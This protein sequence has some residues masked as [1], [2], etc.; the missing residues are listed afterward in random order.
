MGTSVFCTQNLHGYSLQFSPFQADRL[1]CATS[2]HYGLS[3]RGALF[4]LSI[5]PNEQPKL[6]SQLNWDD[7]LFDVAWSEENPEIVISASG[8]GSLQLWNVGQNVPRLVYKEHS[9][10]VYGVDWSKTRQEQLFLSASWD[11][12]VKLWNPVQ[13]HSLSTF[14]GHTGIVYS[15]VWSPLVHGTFA[16]VSGDGSLQICNI[17]APQNPVLKVA[18]H[19]GAE[20]L[21]CDWCKYQ[22]HILVTAASDGLIRGWDTR[23]LQ[24]PI[25]HQIGCE[26]AVR[27]VQ[28]SPHQ[29]SV[30]AA[31]SYDF[32][33]RIWDFKNCAEP[34]ETIKQH[35]EFV[36]G[37]DFNLHVP[38]QLADC[39]WDSLVCV[40]T[41]KTLIDQFVLQRPR[42]LHMQK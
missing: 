42:A 26:R 14:V 32:S 36:Y 40:F 33:T 13:P 29:R 39:A 25:F 23:K 8:D 28:F 5:L 21:S 9:K 34:I 41:P 17:T 6:L 11:C 16:S 10:E 27:K 12:T 31:V 20:V 38:G 3:G 30:L 37:L 19:Q 4:L 22:E 18:A 2:Q 35:T 1:I 7:G 15:A 24:V